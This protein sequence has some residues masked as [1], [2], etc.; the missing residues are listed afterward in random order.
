MHWV[1]D[2]KRSWGALLLCAMFVVGCLPA[3]ARGIHFSAELGEPVLM[4]GKK[5]TAYLKV[6]IEGDAIPGTERAP[7]NVAIVLDKSGSMGGEKIHQAKKAALMAIDKL[8]AE[9]IVSVILYDSTVDVLV[10]ATKASDKQSI[11]NRLRPVGAQGSTALFG[12]VSKAAGEIEKFLD[13]DRVNRVILLSDGLANVGPSSPK[14]LGNLGASLAKQGIAVTTIGLGLDYNE[15]LMAQLARQSNGSHL[16]AEQPSDLEKAYALEFGDLLTAVAQSARVTIRCTEGVRPV[17]IIGRDGTITGQDISLDLGQVY[18]KQ[19][20][21][22]IIE[23]EVP[24]GEKGGRMEIASAQLNC[25]SLRSKENEEY[26]DTAAIRFTDSEKEVE[27][28]R[29]A[30]TMVSVIRQ[31]G[32][33]QTARARG[34]R[35]EGKVE[36]ARQLL[37]QNIVLFDENAARYNSSRLR[38]D[39]L[40]NDFDGQLMDEENWK[41]RRKVMLDKEARDALQSLAYMD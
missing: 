22:A 41:Q 19:V 14:E 28:N 3:G 1:A 36:E 20:K 5:Q 24:A 39:A 21:Y 37:H 30:R 38:D 9:D 34:L 12:G 2:M 40:S 29:D 17:R 25:Y 26:A 35:D 8:N 27:D 18:G 11:W 10:P 16:F 6:R 33:E 31:I 4:E 13:L 15:D 7:T 23:L 32:A